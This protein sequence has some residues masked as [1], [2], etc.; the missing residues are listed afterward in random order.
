MK[1]L[2]FTQYKVLA[3]IKDSVRENEGFPTMRRI[4][5]NFGWKSDNSAY[6]H[7]VALKKKGFIKKGSDTRYVLSAIEDT[8]VR[9]ISVQCECGRV[10]PV[11]VIV[12]G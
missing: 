6:V 9:S 12:S 2:T 10:V 7:I 11:N 3:F 5:D 1:H 4:A 8:P